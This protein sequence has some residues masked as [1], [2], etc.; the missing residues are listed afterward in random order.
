MV[1]TRLNSLRA[2]AVWFLSLHVIEETYLCSSA[3]L[4]NLKRKLAMYLRRH[5]AKDLIYF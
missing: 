2:R 4:E 1:R 3:V 5:A